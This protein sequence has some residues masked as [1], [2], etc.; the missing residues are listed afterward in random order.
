MTSAKSV[1]SEEGMGGEKVEKARTRRLLL[2]LL[3]WIYY[4]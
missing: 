4:I 1:S 2:V 3:F